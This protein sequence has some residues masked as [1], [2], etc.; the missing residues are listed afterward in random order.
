MAKHGP[1]DAWMLIGGYNVGVDLT[2]FEDSNEA[3]LEESH[4]LGDSWVEQSYVG[5]RQAT[6]SIEGFYD[7]SQVGAH[8][9]LEQPETTTPSAKI[10]CWGVAGSTNGVDFYGWAGAAQKSYERQLQLGSLVKV[11][12]E[13]TNDGPADLGKVIWY[14]HVPTATGASTGGAIGSAVDFGASST[15]AAAYLQYYSTSGEANIRVLHSADN[16]TFATLFT[17]TK[18]TKGTA[19][20]VWGAERLTTTGSVNRYIAID[21]TTASATGAGTTNGLSF[22]VGLARNLT[23]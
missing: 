4:T 11:A 3:Q 19:A 2:K 6:V 5:V 17:F 22:F 18:T 23:S 1:A 12:A 16:L 8:R 13:F 9:L 20:G 10:C 7:D 21:I 14:N 15:G